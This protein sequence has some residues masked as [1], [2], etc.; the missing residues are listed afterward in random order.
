MLLHV[1][2]NSQRARIVVSDDGAGM[3]VDEAARAFDRFAQPGITPG[4]ERALGLGLPLAKQFIEA[5]GGRV[6]L[7]SEPGQGSLVTVELPRR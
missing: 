7:V 6:S 4:Q 3:T 5:H 2:G 1:D